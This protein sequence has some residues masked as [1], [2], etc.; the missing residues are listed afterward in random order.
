MIDLSNNTVESI[1][2]KAMGAVIDDEKTDIEQFIFDEVCKDLTHECQ[3]AQTYIVKEFKDSICDIIGSCD[4]DH[5]ICSVF[6]KKGNSSPVFEN[7]TSAQFIC[8]LACNISPVNQL[9][10]EAGR[11]V[12]LVEEESRLRHLGL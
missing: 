4:M 6:D 10:A 7:Q 3:E 1:L 2:S 12:E 8:N 9:C 5:K 11:A